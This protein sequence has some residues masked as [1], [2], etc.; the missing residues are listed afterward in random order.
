M[1]AC[2]SLRALPVAL[3]AKALFI[4]VELTLLPTVA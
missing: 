2:F 1:G 4:S 3:H